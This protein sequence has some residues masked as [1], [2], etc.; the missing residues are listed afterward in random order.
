MRSCLEIA[1]LIGLLDS[2]EEEAGSISHCNA[3]G[4]SSQTEQ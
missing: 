2:S 3:G 1:K 4:V